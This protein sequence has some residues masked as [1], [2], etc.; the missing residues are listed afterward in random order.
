MTLRDTWHDWLG[1]AADTITGDQLER[2]DDVSRA[3]E[4]R[5]PDP[6]LRDDRETA[7][8]AA[9]QVI[10]GD[11]TLEQIAEAWHAARRVE[12]ERMV[13]LT[14]ALLASHTGARSGPGS[15][16]DLIQRSGAARATVRKALGKNP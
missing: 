12:R 16:S 5:W 1:P 2:L 3:I 4:A 8:S 14:G 10:L 11:D 6:D 7:L 9:A 15:E 13:A